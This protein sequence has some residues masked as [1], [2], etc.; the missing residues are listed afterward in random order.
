MIRREPANFSPGPWVVWDGGSASGG[1]EHWT[2]LYENA[3]V[4]DQ[5]YDMS[6]SGRYVFY[7]AYGNWYLFDAA[8]RKPRFLRR[9]GFDC[10][11]KFYEDRNP[12]FLRCY[13]LR[14]NDLVDIALD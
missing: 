5:H 1:P 12:P 2:L 6:P 9:A 10:T 8:R 4:T 13:D 14:G 7:T 11:V 3:F